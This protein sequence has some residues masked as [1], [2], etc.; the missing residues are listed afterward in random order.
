MAQDGWLRAE[1]GVTEKKRDA[2]FYSIT[3]AGRKQLVV[4][5]ESWNRLR[6]G[7]ARVLRYA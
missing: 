2:K 6:Q 5:Q 7:V 3:V 4:E 1:W